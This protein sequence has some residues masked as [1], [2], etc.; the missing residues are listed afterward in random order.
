MT[1]TSNIN[2]CIQSISVLQLYQENLTMAWRSSGT[3]NAEMVDKLTS[4]SN[5]HCDEPF[6]LKCW[7]LLCCV[8]VWL[9]IFMSSVI[10][11]IMICHL[12]TK[13][14]FGYVSIARCSLLHYTSLLSHV[15]SRLF[16]S[17]HTNQTAWRIR[18][19]HKWSCWE[20]ISQSWSQILCSEG[21]S[22]SHHKVT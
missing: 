18:S 19:Y 14:L 21:K 15:I 7:M 8:C 2:R 10:S 1:N 9:G 16:R 12:H 5:F 22:N 20:S 6:Y 17:S 11:Y 3:N 13:V 4:K